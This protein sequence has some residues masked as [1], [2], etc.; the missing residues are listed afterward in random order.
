[1][2]APFR[3]LIFLDQPLKIRRN[4]LT[5]DSR[6][7][8]GMHLQ[9]MFGNAGMERQETHNLGPVGHAQNFIVDGL[10]NLNRRTSD[11]YI[12]IGVRDFKFG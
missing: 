4:F 11:Y 9:K 6:G 2:F 12:E 10:R 1:M 8:E 5:N 7:L 3:G